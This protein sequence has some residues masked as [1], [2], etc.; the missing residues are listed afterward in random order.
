VTIQRGKLNGKI[1]KLTHSVFIAN[2]L[3]LCPAITYKQ[4]SAYFISLGNDLV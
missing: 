1:Y 2:P 3:K 4:F